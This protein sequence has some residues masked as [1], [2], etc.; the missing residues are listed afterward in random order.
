MHALAGLAVE[1][2]QV[3]AP[4]HPG[5][6]YQMLRYLAEVFTGEQFGPA[7]GRVSGLIVA[8]VFALL[9]FSAVKYSDRRLNRDFVL[10][11]TRG[12]DAQGVP[13]T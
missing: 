5:V 9:L 2:G 11:V 1:R 6:R 8:T 10:N 4:G 3:N 7:D 12:R 13:D